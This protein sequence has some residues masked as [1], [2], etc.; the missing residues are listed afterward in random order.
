VERFDKLSVDTIHTLT[1]GTGVTVP[2]TQTK[3]TPTN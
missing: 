1:E 3:P 2:V